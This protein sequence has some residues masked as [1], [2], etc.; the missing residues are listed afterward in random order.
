[1]ERIEVNVTT[2]QILTI[3]LT[4]DEVAMAQAQYAAWEA[5]QNSVPTV[6]VQ[7]QIA[8]LTAELEALKLKAGV[9]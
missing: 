3:Q 9:Q 8:A 4:A 5:Q 7:D 2:G 6:T 1:M